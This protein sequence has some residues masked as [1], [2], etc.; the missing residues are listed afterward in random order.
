[1]KR[2]RYFSRKKMIKD[3]LTFDWETY[4]NTYDDLYYIN[5]KEEAWY[6]WINY[7][8]IENR[9]ICSTEKSSEPTEVTDEFKQFDWEIY[10]NNYADLSD[11]NSKEEA[12]LHWCTHGKQENR[13]MYDL[14]NIN[15]VDDSNE[16]NWE[17][18][19][20]NYADL[21]DISSKEEAWLHW[22]TH[23]KQEN[24]TIY[25][26]EKS[27]EFNEFDWETYKNNYADLSDIS[28]KEEAWVHW[29][30][31][32]K[33]ENRIFENIFSFDDYKT[34]DWKTYINNYD[35]L[36]N[37]Q[38]K[39]EAWKH[40][41]VC[42]FTEDRKTI[43][44]RQIEINEYNKI[45]EDED[46]FQEH[47]FASNNLYF[48][49]K[50]TNCGKHFFGWKAT[51]NYLIQHLHFSET[52]YKQK[53][54][55]DE[56]IEKLLI[57]GNK[58]QSKQYLDIIHEENLQLISFLHCPPFE[59]YS[60]RDDLL[61]NDDLCLN[62]KMI[63]L[64]HKNNLFHSITFLYVLSVHHKH[65]IINTYPQ[66]K[67]KVLSVYHPIDIDNNSKNELFDI[68]KF[69]N[70][71]NIC[72]IGWWLRNFNSFINFEVPTGYNKV[73]L[74]K[75]EFKKHFD[76]KFGNEICDGNKNIQI[77][78]ELKDNDYVKLFN[79]S[80]IF[81]D[82]VDCVANNVVLECIKY[83][84][85]IIIRRLPSLEE[86]LGKNY[87]LFFNDD[88][89]LLH[90]KSEDILMKK[91]QEANVYLK[92]LNKTPFMLN[93]FVNKI[94][95]DLNKLR[96][97]DNV[98]KLTWLCYLNNP[99]DDI[100]RYISKF[101]CQLSIKKI[102]L[103]IVNS[104]ANKV[105]ILKNYVHDSITIINVDSS[106]DMNEVYNIFIS[107]T[108]TEYMTYKKF[109]D[110][111][112]EE[113]YSDLCIN[114]LDNNLTFDII[115]F[116]ELPVVS[117]ENVIEFPEIYNSDMNDFTFHNNENDNKNENENDLCDSSESS[118][119]SISSNEGDNEGDN[120]HMYLHY[121]N[122]KKKVE[123]ESDS[124]ET[125]V[126][127]NVDKEELYKKNENEILLTYSQIDN[128]IFDD[129]NTN[130]LWRKSVHS[131][132]TTFDKDFWLNCY[133]NNINIF[134]INV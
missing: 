59:S 104:L 122:N 130:I 117:R 124:D 87:P 83:N 62:K 78:N 22:C 113:S 48:K 90:F 118:K 114:Y 18:Y 76:E 11:I 125:E 86:Y 12:W 132:I 109:H 67:N 10:K 121:T 56:W 32:G 91:I 80:C 134:Q 85:P 37:I 82:L 106:V 14:K 96:V 34:F 128:N 93:S 115:L 45:I 133:K 23:G 46:T 13:R 94:N 15:N 26:I 126:E 100:E 27:K 102:K 70:N 77:I 53:Y 72:H 63:D 99:E 3:F 49:K 61:L 73:I 89:E 105:K 29:Y 123:I 68:Y 52:K 58:I 33:Q 92:N 19:K 43:D 65:Y 6:H 108:T 16:F 44:I 112:S 131:V 116:S 74:V 28:S 103:L 97:N 42:G 41:I 31:H 79:N 127:N 119:L 71:K 57:W 9:S 1:M 20:N 36:K 2:S 69:M 51:M 39:E 88:D 107:N 35:D 111:N 24:R 120:E 110:L 75:Q 84:T 129:P 30:T 17:T 64:I 25:A 21:S 4:K 50:Y 7:G 66:L 98:Y 81:C 95:Y 54:Y 38:T 101:C 5:T 40:F 8:K 60:K 55:L 47:D